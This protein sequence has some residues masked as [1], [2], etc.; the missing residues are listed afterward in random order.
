M[1][2]EGSLWWLDRR[3]YRK[4]KVRMFWVGDIIKSLVNIRDKRAPHV[5]FAAQVAQIY[6]KLL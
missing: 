5:R 4:S 2:S 1:P 3:I 6:W